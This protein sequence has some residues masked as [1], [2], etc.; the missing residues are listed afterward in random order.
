MN[1]RNI[2]VAKYEPLMKKMC[3]QFSFHEV[4]RAEKN[5]AE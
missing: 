2:G 1:T 5:F 3:A 4:N